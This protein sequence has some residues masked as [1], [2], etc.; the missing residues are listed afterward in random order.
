VPTFDWLAR[1]KREYRRLPL[2]QRRRFRVA[3]GK[4]VAALDET[5]PRLPGEP[6]TK[7]VLGTAVCTSASRRQP[8]REATENHTRPGHPFASGVAGRSQLRGGVR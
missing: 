5:P 3:V 7:A 1:F 6:L 8:L 4:L 2:E